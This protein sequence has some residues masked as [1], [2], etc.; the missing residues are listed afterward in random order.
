MSGNVIV[1]ARLWALMKKDEYVLSP[2]MINDN[3]NSIRPSFPGRGPDR[4]RRLASKDA[5]YQVE[6]RRRRLPRGNRL[7]DSSF[8]TARAHCGQ[9][10]DPVDKGNLLRTF[11]IEDP[12]TFARTLFI[13]RSSGRA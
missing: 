5:G 9:G 13:G 10:E 8:N 3:L 7:I 1:D 6:S 12:A 11:Q 4:N 2:I